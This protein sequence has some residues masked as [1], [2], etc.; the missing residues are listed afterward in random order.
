MRDDYP[1]VD[2]AHVNSI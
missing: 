1:F 2:E